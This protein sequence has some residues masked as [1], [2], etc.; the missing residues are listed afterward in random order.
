M[1]GAGIICPAEA[2]SIPAATAATAS[3]LGF[4]V[5]HLRKSSVFSSSFLSAPIGSEIFRTCESAD[6]ALP[7]IVFIMGS[8]VPLMFFASNR[9]ALISVKQRDAG[10]L[11]ADTRFEYFCEKA[12]K[13]EIAP[14]RFPIAAR[15]QVYMIPQ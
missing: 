12:S 10:Y 8:V 4:F 15:Q 7:Q 3:F 11:Q 1:F 5:I 2:D 9:A 6:A 14:C 13:K